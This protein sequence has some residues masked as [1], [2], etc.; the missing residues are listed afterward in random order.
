MKVGAVVAAI[1]YTETTVGAFVTGGS[2]VD[3]TAIGA[4]AQ[5]LWQCR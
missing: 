1:E 5:Q 3:E 2:N 4:C